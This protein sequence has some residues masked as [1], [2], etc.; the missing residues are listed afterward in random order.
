MGALAGYRV[1]I[2]GKLSARPT[3]NLDGVSV[4]VTRYFL[5]DLPIFSRGCA[6][7]IDKAP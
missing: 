6:E 5:Y 7:N 3:S 1:A 4:Q 2:G